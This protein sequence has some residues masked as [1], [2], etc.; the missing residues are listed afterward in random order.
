[1]K[2]VE[3]LQNIFYFWN[4]FLQTLGKIFISFRNVSN[5]MKLLTGE[6]VCNTHRK[7][8]AEINFISSGPTSWM[9]IYM[10]KSKVKKKKQQHFKISC[11]K[12]YVH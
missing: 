1:M 3:Y 10:V 4:C 11:V 7:S 2:K 9:V 6:V 8:L 5:P 12:G